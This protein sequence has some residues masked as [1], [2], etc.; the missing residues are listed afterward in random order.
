MAPLGS[1]CILAFAPYTIIVFDAD[2]TTAKK[3]VQS[4][5]PGNSYAE[6]SITA[7]GIGPGGLLTVVMAHLAVQCKDYASQQ[8]DKGVQQVEDFL[9]C[10][11]ILRHALLDANELHNRHKRND[12]IRDCKG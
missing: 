11:P 8:A 4:E 9:S 12:A 5:S 10:P 1:F 7:N 6:G 2:S 3:G